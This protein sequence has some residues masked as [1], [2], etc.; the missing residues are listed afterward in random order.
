MDD[1]SVPSKLRSR[2]VVH[3]METNVDVISLATRQVMMT[4]N[5]LNSTFQAFRGITPTTLDKTIQTESTLVLRFR[6]QRCTLCT[7]KNVARKRGLLLAANLYIEEHSTR[8]LICLL[9][10]KLQYYYC[11]Y[12]TRYCKG[13]VKY[14]LYTQPTPHHSK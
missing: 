11:T 7:R 13:S 5:S 4:L 3:H 14:C 2:R 8:H 1:W 9:D 6:S 12:C 10:C